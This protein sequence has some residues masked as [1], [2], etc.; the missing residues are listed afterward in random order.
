MAVLKEREI[1][2]TETLRADEGEV[3][4]PPSPSETPVTDTKRSAV[5]KENRI[6]FRM[7]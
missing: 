1:G 5:L 3:V 7:L 2:R 6:D 4:K